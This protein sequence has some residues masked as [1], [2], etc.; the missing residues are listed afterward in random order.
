MANTPTLQDCFRGRVSRREYSQAIGCERYVTWYLDG[1]PQGYYWVTYYA[2]FIEEVFEFIGVPSTLKDS[3]GNVS[4]RDACGNQYTVSLT[5]ACTVQGTQMFETLS[6]K[7]IRE[8]MSPH[9][10]RIVVTHRTGEIVS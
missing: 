10:W 3:T 7:V 4:V 6:N 9:M 8:Q 1:V 5:Q 2:K